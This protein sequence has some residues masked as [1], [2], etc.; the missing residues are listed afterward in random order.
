METWREGG[1]RGGD[2]AV[3]HT[4]PQHNT[5]RMAMAFSSFFFSFLFVPGAVSVCTGGK[6][7]IVSYLSVLPCIFGVC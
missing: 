3:Q 6:G 5:S 4:T 1:E 7:C 2:L